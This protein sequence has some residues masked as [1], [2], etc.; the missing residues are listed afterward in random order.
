MENQILGKKY[1]TPE[2]IHLAYGSKYFIKLCIYVS[3][4]WKFVFFK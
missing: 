1:I 4:N 2:Q 3:V